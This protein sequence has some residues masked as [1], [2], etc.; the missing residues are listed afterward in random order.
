MGGIVVCMYV[1]VCV[2]IYIYIYR[3]R[4][5]ERE[6]ICLLRFFSI[7]RDIQ[8]YLITCTKLYSGKVT[9]SV[10]QQITFIQCIHICVYNSLQ[11]YL[12]L[13]SQY[14]EYYAFNSIHF[15]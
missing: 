12:N 1:C 5:R 2:Y 6:S 8:L 14:Y 4:E 7:I 15:I 3:E 13:N 11:Y 10:S 9:H